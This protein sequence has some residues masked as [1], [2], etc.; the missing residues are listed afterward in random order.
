MNS[1]LIETATKLPLDKRIELIEVLWESLAEEGYEPS[2][3]PEQTAELD[4][5]LEAHRK[6]PNDVVPWESI[7]Q[8]LLSEYHKR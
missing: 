4:R 1:H 5:R 7:K 8:E 6:N 3:T 2:L